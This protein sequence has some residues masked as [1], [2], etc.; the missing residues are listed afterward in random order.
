MRR[1]LI[2]DIMTPLS[3]FD[4][5]PRKRFVFPRWLRALVNGTPRA[6]AVPVRAAVAKY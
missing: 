3:A 1:I 2:N 5:F 6:E 4:L